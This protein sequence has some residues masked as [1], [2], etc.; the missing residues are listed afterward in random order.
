M[1]VFLYEGQRLLRLFH[2]VPQSY[3]KFIVYV[4]PLLNDCPG[5]L[6]DDHQG[7]TGFDQPGV[8]LLGVFLFAASSQTSPSKLLQRLGW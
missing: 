8:N 6:F 1:A 7:M 5:G 4:Y 2:I 3:V